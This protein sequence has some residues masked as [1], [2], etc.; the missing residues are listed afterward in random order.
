MNFDGNTCG[1]PGCIRPPRSE[2][3]F[4]CYRHWWL[5]PVS[6]RR[7]VR[8]AYQSYEHGYPDVELLEAAQR[9]AVEAVMRRS[10]T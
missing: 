3:I 5:T 7:Q 6:L 4:L 10:T 8:A 1:I 9:E 2:R